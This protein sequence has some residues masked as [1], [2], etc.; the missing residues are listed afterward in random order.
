MKIR[1]VNYDDGQIPPWSKVF[2]L[3]YL[4]NGLLGQ[5]VPMYAFIDALLIFGAEQRCIHDYL[6]GTKVVD[7]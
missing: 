3:R 1:I 5:V 2:G 6:A 7:A 4:V